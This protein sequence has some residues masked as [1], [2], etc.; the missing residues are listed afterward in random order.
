MKY[1]FITLLMLLLPCS[2][3]AQKQKGQIVESSVTSGARHGLEGVKVSV[4]GT[5]NS[6][7]T[8][9]KG[10]FMMSMHSYN[11]AGM[12]YYITE[13]SKKGFE[14]ADPSVLGR[15]LAY[16]PKELLKVSLLSSKQLEAERSR[17]ENN[18]YQATY[19]QLN[20]HLNALKDSLDKELISTDTYRQRRNSLE[21]QL[22]RYK[23]LISVLADHYAR[24]DY[25]TMNEKDIEVCVRI[26]EGEF[27]KADSLLN[28]LEKEWQL[29]QEKY[30][31]EKNDVANDL[32]NKYAIAIARFD[33]EKAQR[34]IY[35]RAE[36]DSTNI[37]CLID[38]G[39]FACEYA[40]DFLKATTY[41][42]NAIIQAK[43]QYGE[44]SEQYA[45]CLNHK[46]GLLLEQ[47]RFEESLDCR[48]KALQIRTALFGETHTSV[49][50][51][52]NNIANIYYAMSNRQKAK[53]YAQKAVSIYRNAENCIAADYAAALNTLGGVLLASDE[54]DSATVLFDDAIKICTEN[55]GEYNVHA[56]TA[57]NDKGVVLDYLDKHEE[58][59]YCYRKA[60][61]IFSKV[62]GSEHPTVATL[63]D[64]LGY[65][66]KKTGQLDSA[67]VYM[68]RS[69]ETRL[70][71]HG[72]LHE[73]VAVS[74]NN[75]GSF[76]ASIKMND[77]A[78]DF[79]GKCL[80]IWDIIMGK[81]YERFAIT[82]AN[83]GDLYYCQKD[84]PMALPC[85][86]EALAFYAQNPV[87]YKKKL[88]NIG[89]LA[90][91]CYQRLL[92]DE[93]LSYYE[94]LNVDYEEFKKLYF[95][96]IDDKE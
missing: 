24:M 28:L 3:F 93:T 25:S 54:M 75:L 10:Y 22:D 40:C 13:I 41:Y 95:K 83:L 71:I 30:N 33:S 57:L 79:Y 56:A 84:Y 12:P 23:P 44:D 91:T 19:R 48:E 58:A 20:T 86:E 69:L 17:I 94:Q 92:Q 34:Y 32:Y 4:R 55:Y 27:A 53:E 29:Q 11:K 87:Q 1:I 62:Y 80:T 26:K 46:G 61:H 42:D 21:S 65:S 35:L 14:L 18:V 59:I 77:L 39:A 31:K 66:Y 64:N 76:C 37:N 81:N 89:S 63:Y 60:I 72:E 78:I 85:F 16:S 52:C 50:A 43:D 70:N 88:K 7:I 82:I 49:A 9:S 5:T 8:D 2:F 6:Y 96:Y 68:T 90:A 47:S 38:A 36:V 45:L 15:P 73:D 74:L 67:M 51:C